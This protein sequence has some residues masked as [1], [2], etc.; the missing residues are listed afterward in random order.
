[1]DRDTRRALLICAGFLILWVVY[2]HLSP[3]TYDD[4]DVTHFFMARESLDTPENLISLWGRPL[5]TLLYALPAQLGYGV[6]EAFTALIMAATL[7]L[8]WRVAR[9]LDLRPA[10][11]A[12]FLTAWQP[13]LF[14]L[15]FSSLVEPLGAL[16]LVA[17]LHALFS[18]RDLQGAVLAGLLPLTRFELIVL[19]PFIVWPIWRRR[20]GLTVLLAALP[21]VLWNVGGWLFEG[22]PIWLASQILNNEFGRSFAGAQPLGHYARALPLITGGAVFVPLVLGLFAP[23]RTRAHGRDLV[24]VMLVSF[25]LVLSLLAWEAHDFGGSVGYLRHVVAVGPVIGLVA[26]MG[27]S[28]WTERP[29]P[30]ALAWAALSVATLGAVAACAFRVYQHVYEHPV[31]RSVEP[32]M[33][34][35]AAGVT[36]ALLVAMRRDARLPFVLALVAAAST[37]AAE[38]PIPLDVERR[39]V[40][41]IVGFIQREA[42]GRKVAVNHPWFF[43]L[44]GADRHD[45]VRYPRLT[46]ETLARLDPGS[47]VVWENHY[48]SRLA[49]DVKLE[50]FLEHPDRYLPRAKDRLDRTRPNGEVTSQFIYLIFEVVHPD[51]PR[52]AAPPGAGR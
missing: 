51:D 21:L 13:I 40:R 44:S 35:V 2:G 26:L 29:R 37:L 52:L 49:G 45:R 33:A 12:I 5:F 43:F 20:P 17:A 18:R 25:T 38:P 27:V 32:W 8:T 24:R 16:T 42:P 7:F 4:D 23:W 41:D 3:G 34:A 19:V 46:H 48:S 28:S 6:V 22:D 36:A 47:F 50:H 30:G 31:N 39:G 14:K 1:M 15:G 9:L 11:L 10:W